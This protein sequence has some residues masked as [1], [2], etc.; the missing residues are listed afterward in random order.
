M[1]TAEVFA[2]RNDI[3]TDEA[4]IRLGRIAGLF[5]QMRSLPLC[6]GID[7]DA[8]VNQLVHF[9][10]V[11]GDPDLAQWHDL[12]QKSVTAWERTFGQNDSHLLMNSLDEF[13]RTMTH[14]RHEQARLDDLCC[15]ILL[16]IRPADR[17]QSWYCSE[18][19]IRQYIEMAL[20]PE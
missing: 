18:G 14:A 11:H 16:Q 3:P 19:E 7:D 5:Q 20:N 15:Q 12:L 8:L 10:M 13:S 6:Q 17:G 9:A 4:V 2:H 1:T